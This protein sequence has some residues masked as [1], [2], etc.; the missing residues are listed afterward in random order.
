M[1]LVS[2]GRKRKSPARLH[3]QGPE[4]LWRTVGLVIPYRVASQQSPIP[5]H[6]AFDTLT[7]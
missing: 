7:Q 6:Q 3:S 5:F 2:K 1:A 4:R